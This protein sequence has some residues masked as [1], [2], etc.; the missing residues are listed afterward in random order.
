MPIILVIWQLGY[1]RKNFGAW[2]KSIIGNLKRIIGPGLACTAVCNNYLGI[3]LFA[4]YFSYFIFIF[5]NYFILTSYGTNHPQ[6]K[7][8]KHV[9][10]VG[11]LGSARVY[12]HTQYLHTCAYAHAV[13][14]FACVFTRVH[15][16]MANVASILAS[17]LSTS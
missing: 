4:F 6:L 11:F 15:V 8:S 9:T 5:G 12:T 2:I 17:Y 1:N 13:F 16:C 3:S 10:R 14:T 7:R